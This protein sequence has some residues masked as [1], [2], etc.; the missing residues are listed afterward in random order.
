MVGRSWR[1]AV[2]VSGRDAFV[3]SHLAPASVRE[4]RSGDGWWSVLHAA[5]SYFD[6][7]GLLVGGD[8]GAVG[9]AVQELCEHLRPHEV[10]VD[11]RV[12]LDFA[13]PEH[14]SRWAWLH[15]T[16]PLPA[17][18]GEELVVW[19]PEAAAVDALLDVANP[20]AFVRPGSPAAH[21]WAA[22]PD[23]DGGLLACG[24]VTFHAPV[25]PHLASVAVAPRARRRG[26]G[27]ALT[28]AM[29]RRLL[30]T[31]PAVSLALW[32]GNTSARALY[33]RVGFTGGHDYATRE[34]L[35]G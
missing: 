9:G 19:S 30:R 25:L 29:V 6:R 26:L 7:G 27:A 16:R 21:A 10:T 1:E 14:G 35:R 20:D 32:A 4:V 34:L 33:D 2:L 5:T 23:T 15:T 22:V 8:V 28:A 18:P 12:P 3:A 17:V 13:H 11:A 31:S 24:A